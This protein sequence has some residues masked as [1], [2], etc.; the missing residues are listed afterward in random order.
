M[1]EGTYKCSFCGKEYKYNSCK[2]SD[3]GAC[4]VNDG[5]AFKVSGGDS[6]QCELTT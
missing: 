1:K 2:V 5:G 6:V 3:Y 4:K